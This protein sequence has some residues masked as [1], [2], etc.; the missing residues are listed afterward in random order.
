MTLIESLVAFVILA[1]VSA[2]VV[3]VSSQGVNDTQSLQNHY[4][5]GLV[6]DNELQQAQ[7]DYPLLGQPIS[8][9]ST[10]MGRQWFWTLQPK[11]TELGYLQQWHIQVFA[12]KDKKQPVGSRVTYVSNAPQVGSGPP[13][14][15]N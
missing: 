11:A 9:E 13:S 14:P 7:L 3:L 1:M 5:A 10:L 4:Y 6:A 8:G 12:D 2:S 15:P